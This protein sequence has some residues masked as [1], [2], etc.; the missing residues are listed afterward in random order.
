MLYKEIPCP[1]CDGHGHI[2]GGDLNSI[3]SIQCSN[4]MGSGLVVSYITNA[5]LIRQ[6]DNEQ[7]VKVYRNLKEWAI[8]SGGEKNRLLDRS[9]EDFSLWLNKVT[10]DIDIKTIFDFIDEKDYEH[11][12]VKSSLRRNNYG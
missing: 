7:L 3:W 10:D 12:Y 11:S 1:E 9:P 2:S 5:D 6:C 4:C 8:Y